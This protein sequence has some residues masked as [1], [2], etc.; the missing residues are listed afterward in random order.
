M[1]KIAVLIMLLAA[2]VFSS[3]SKSGNNDILGRWV[4]VEVQDKVQ[5]G[6][7]FQQRIREQ[8][9]KANFPIGS[10]IEF[11]KKGLAHANGISIEYDFPEKG[12]LRMHSANG[13]PDTMVDYVIDGDRMQWDYG[14]VVV[15]FEREGSGGLNGSSGKDAGD[16]NRAENPD[17]GG[18]AASLEVLPPNYRSLASEVFAKVQ[19]TWVGH[20][21]DDRQRVELTI[22]NMRPPVGVGFK[23]SDMQNATLVESRIT[24]TVALKPNGDI[25]ADESF[26]PADAVMEITGYLFLYRMSGD[27][28][29]TVWVEVNDEKKW[30]K[31]D[32][33]AELGVDLDQ[34]SLS[35]GVKAG[36]PEGPGEGTIHPWNE[37][38]TG[39]TRVE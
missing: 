25:P 20:A 6:N 4:I 1:R 17:D 14:D 12:K 32:E 24:A 16:G 21:F 8:S 30:I 39:M 28:D 9:V 22:H 3:C 7:Y 13:A 38:L 19:G 10:A 15:T 27:D 35:F 2:T 18:S 33:R 34:F 37:A 23:D 31:K 11:M 26:T 36:Q 29:Y 5:T